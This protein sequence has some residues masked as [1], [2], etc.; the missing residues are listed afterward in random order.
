MP[1][2]G[3][4]QRFRGST[5]S[6]GRIPPCQSTCPQD[7]ASSAAPIPQHEA[8]GV[9][10]T[11]GSR[12]SQWPLPNTDCTHCR[13][14]GRLLGEAATHW[15]APTTPQPTLHLVGGSCFK[16]TRE[17]GLALELQDPSV[18]TPT[19]LAGRRGLAHDPPPSP[20]PKR[21][22]G[23]EERNRGGFGTGSQPVFT[24]ACPPH[25]QRA[26]SQRGAAPTPSSSGEVGEYAFEDTLLAPLSTCLLR[27]HAIH[28]KTGKWMQR[29]RS[30]ASLPP[31][32]WQDGAAGAWAC[33]C[34][35]AVCQATPGGPG[36]RPSHHP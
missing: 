29:G 3:S 31:R 16:G 19:Q 4:E 34:A 9:M 22:L 10:C 25:A 36:E 24:G 13:E 33:L 18:K 15:E 6:A 17:T 1:R 5:L 30:K 35:P 7:T 20:S 32:C 12:G 23:T 26:D 14:V 27:P 8:E 28:S 21:D 2:G 11:E